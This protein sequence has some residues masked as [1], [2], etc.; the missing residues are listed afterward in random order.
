MTWYGSLPSGGSLE[1]R[2]QK[3]E[4]DWYSGVN[5]KELEANKMAEQEK[6]ESDRIAEQELSKKKKGGGESQPSKEQPIH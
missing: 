3:G 1:Q 4:V 2:R 6:P 5:G